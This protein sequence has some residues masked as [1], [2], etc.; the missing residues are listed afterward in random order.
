MITD[1]K[2][3][4]K[5]RRVKSVENIFRQVAEE[6]PYLI[7]PFNEKKFH[8]EAE[9]ILNKTISEEYVAWWLSGFRKRAHP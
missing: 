5:L 6:K 2:I 3:L 7:A 8:R 4:K 9:R 1:T